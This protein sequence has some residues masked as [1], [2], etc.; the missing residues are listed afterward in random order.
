MSVWQQAYSPA[1]VCAYQHADLF[2]TRCP[3]MQL[4]TALFEICCLFMYRARRSLVDSLSLLVPPCLSWR[5]LT[6]RGLQPWKTREIRLASC[7]VGTR[8]NFRSQTGNAARGMSACSGAIGGAKCHRV[9]GGGCLP[10]SPRHD[11]SQIPPQ[12]S[13]STGSTL[14]EHCA[15]T[16]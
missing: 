6:S 4:C 16:S 11:Q 10:S 1:C 5:S 13:Q 2:G 8:S 15:G 12:G 3:F 9:T 7:K 14:T